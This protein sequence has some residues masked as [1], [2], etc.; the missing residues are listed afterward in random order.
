M[1]IVSLGGKT[2]RIADGALVTE[3][4]WIIGDVTIEEGASVWFN[5][6]IRGDMDSIVIGRNSNIQDLCMIHADR[7]MPVLIGRGVTLGHGAIV[8]AAT[9]DD[10]VLIGMNAVVLNRAHIGEGSI[11][12]ANAVVSAGKDIPPRSMVLGIPG[13]VVRE[14]DEEGLDLIKHHADSYLETCRLYHPGAAPG[15]YEG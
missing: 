10:N 6:V 13:K 7:G 5:A 2:P 8:H 14:V 1:P 15:D 3:G 12:G 4:A 11:V 9:V